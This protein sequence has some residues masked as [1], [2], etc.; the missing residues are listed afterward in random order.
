MPRP[1]R[2][3][4]I[5][6]RG[7]AS[8]RPRPGS[9]GV[10]MVFSSL[11]RSRVASN[12][13]SSAIWWQSVRNS[14]GLVVW[15]RRCVSRWAARGCWRMVRA[16][17]ISDFGFLI[18]TFR[19]GQAQRAEAA[20]GHHNVL[21]EERKSK[22]KNRKSLEQV[23]VDLVFEDGLE[24]L[25]E[26]LRRTPQAWQQGQPVIHLG[27]HVFWHGGLLAQNPVKRAHDVG[28]DDF[29]N[30]LGG[31]RTVLAGQQVHVHQPEP[32]LM[33]ELPVQ[34]ETVEDDGF[35][36][37]VEAAAEVPGA[38]V[39]SPPY[40]RVAAEQHGRNV[41]KLGEQE[42]L[43]GGGAQLGTLEIEE[44]KIA[45]CQ[46]AQVPIPHRL[47]GEAAVLDILRQHALEAPVGPVKNR[48]GQV[49]VSDQVFGIEQAAGEVDCI[50][51]L[52]FHAGT[53]T[54]SGRPVRLLNV[55]PK[56]IDRPVTA[57]P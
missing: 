41:G 29:A 7:W 13:S 57:L 40:T 2:R 3:M 23:A 48:L 16:I 32:P 36:P 10:W 44:G 47:G 34:R 1:A 43:P 37:R 15:S 42:F 49:G 12:A 50:A 45:R 52:F 38:A 18:L 11:A 28:G 20:T 55:F 30:R 22:T 33:G 24:F 4:G 14:A 53:G 35:R 21:I 27:A 54:E 51:G 8:T 5:I 26:L 39:L 19:P 56:G 6:A 25:P 31:G 46:R 17:S 9:R